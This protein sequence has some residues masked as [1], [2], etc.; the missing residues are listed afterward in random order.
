MGLPLTSITKLDGLP[1]LMTVY[2]WLKE[3]NSFADEFARAKED[4]ADTYFGL[5]L[6]WIMDTTPENA[7]DR[8]VQ[9]EGAKWYM[10][11]LKPSIYGDTKRIEAEITQKI[12]V[13]T[14][15]ILERLAQL[16]KA[17][18]PSLQ[19]GYGVVVEAVAAE[20]VNENQAEEQQEA[21]SDNTVESLD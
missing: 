11:R 19:P 20:I 2:K 12:T 4:Q 8:R 17:Y 21:E 7:A 18:V 1:G 15:P 6:S 14:T 5:I 16:R 3:N 13:D 10:S 9:I